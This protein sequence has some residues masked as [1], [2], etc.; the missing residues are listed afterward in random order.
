MQ[1]REVFDL[2]DQDGADQ[3]DWIELR[4]ALRGIGF[5]ITKKEA[6]ELL[7][8]VDSNHDGL[9]DFAEFIQVC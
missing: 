2:V 7:R 4:G 6:R 5:A 8:S 3:L 1:L 9:I